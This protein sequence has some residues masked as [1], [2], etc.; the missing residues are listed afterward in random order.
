MAM[1]IFGESPYIHIIILYNSD[2]ILYYDE[3]NVVDRWRKIGG[4]EG[5]CSRESGEWH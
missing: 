5:A 2:M 4:T 1:H 3:D